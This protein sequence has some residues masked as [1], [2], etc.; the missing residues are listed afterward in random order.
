MFVA[1]YLFLVIQQ[2]LRKQCCEYMATKFKHSRDKQNHLILWS[3][4]GENKLDEVLLVPQPHEH[5]LVALR[6]SIETGVE[7]HDPVKKH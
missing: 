4:L 6:H 2:Q 5:R 1:P 7:R 3:S